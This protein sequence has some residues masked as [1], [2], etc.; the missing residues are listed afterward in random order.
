MQSVFDGGCANPVYEPEPDLMTFTHNGKRALVNPMIGGWAVVSNQEL[1]Q[2][3]RVKQPLPR[4]LGEEA[5]GHGLARKNGQSVFAGGMYEDVLFFE[6][7][8][9]DECNLA[10]RYCS[11]GTTPVGT[12]TKADPAIGLKWVDRVY[13]YAQQH[14]MRNLILEITGGEPL[15]N[16]EYLDRIIGYAMLQFGQEICAKI[17][18]VTNLTILGPRQL[19]L[20]HKYPII[21]AVSLDGDR[22]SH[23][24]QRLFASG[25]PTW[26]VVMNN[27]RK[28]AD[29]G[30]PPESLQTTITS[31]TVERMTD[32]VR[33]LM[34]MG[35]THLSLQHMTSTGSP[36]GSRYLKPDPCLY[37]EKLFQV[38]REQ[39]I[40]F[41]RTTGAM[42]Y[43]RHLSIC[44]AYLLEPKRTYMCQSSPCG[45]GR[46]IICTKGN[47]DVFG[48]ATGPW[49]E[50]LRYGNI[51]RD[52][53]EV[54]QR[55]AA[56]TAS[57]SRQVSA[58][59]KCGSC[60]WRGWCHGGCPKEAYGATG[61]IFE[62]SDS[63]ELH[64]RLFKRALESLMDNEF[65]EE[66]IREQAKYYLK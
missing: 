19:E 44:Y 56:A 18:I 15:A 36:P 32:T 50:A 46:N 30:L 66:A 64:Q 45:A 37:V 35:Y 52:S 6:L 59:P 47:G 62:P 11:S 17:I 16:V 3:L 40:P 13:E 9:S 41:W 54:C 31:Q 27:I 60:L 65:P 63:C 29:H 2:L 21:L 34:D 57:A 1:V 33:L 4:R 23:N 58:L 24:A 10:C 28:L 26:D 42:P 43:A 49:D 5:Y 25:N 7:H 8:I 38:F 48:C 51:L 22:E 39:F 61:S 55:S 14:N 53:F 12:I 20:L